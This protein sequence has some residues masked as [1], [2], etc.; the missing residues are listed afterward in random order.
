VHLRTGCQPVDSE[1]RLDFKRLRG[2]RLILVRLILVANKEPSSRRHVGTQPHDPAPPN[3]VDLYPY[4]AP[5][6]P[7]FVLKN[8]INGSQKKFWESERSICNAC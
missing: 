6:E 7:R 3:C 8:G 4:E 5:I 2:V 1:S